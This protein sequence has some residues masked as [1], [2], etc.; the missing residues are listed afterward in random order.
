L[1]KPLF[2]IACFAMFLLSGCQY[3][4][5]CAYSGYRPI[6]REISLVFGGTL[7]LA[8]NSGFIYA[9]DAD[10][11]VEKWKFALTFA[12]DS[13]YQPRITGVAIYNGLLWFVEAE[14]M[15]RG[16]NIDTGVVVREFDTGFGSIQAHPAVANGMFYYHDSKSVYAF[17]LVTESLRWEYSVEWGNFAKNISTMSYA[18]G[19]IYVN[20]GEN[21]SLYALD[22][23]TGNEKWRY[24]GETEVP[25]KFTVTN[26]L[27]YLWDNFLFIFDAYTGVEKD[28][29]E[30]MQGLTS[31]P[32]IH[33]GIA[34]YGA[35]RWTDDSWGHDYAIDTNTGKEKWNINKG[36][37]TG[38]AYAVSAYGDMAYFTYYDLFALDAYTGR[39]KWKFDVMETRAYGEIE[40]RAVVVDDTAYFATAK[41][42]LFAINAVTGKEKWRFKM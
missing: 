37:C 20:G 5:D 35:E 2:V 40:S 19:I 29:Y 41:D 36:E 10:T 16:L 26:G 1:R 38:G 4:K 28:R 17:D 42:F 24:A 9:V 15:I 12:K 18:N 23:I 3:G 33:N 39:H 34:Y 8:S 32:V 31:S 11:G 22:A 7:F 21:N 6:E 30:A 14:G 25:S 13:Y 27:V